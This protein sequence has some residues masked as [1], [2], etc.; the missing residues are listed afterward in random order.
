MLGAAFLE[1]HSLI[2]FLIGDRVVSRHSAISITGKIEVHGEHVLQEDFDFP[3]E[4]E[5]MVT[6][7][8]SPCV[9]WTPQ[10]CLP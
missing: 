8:H 10:P 7:A 1:I 2:S 5:D 3:R 6:S 4:V 9:S